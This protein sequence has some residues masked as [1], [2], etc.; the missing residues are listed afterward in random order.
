VATAIVRGTV[1]VTSRAVSVSPTGEILYD[2]K[3]YL[4]GTAP[5]ADGQQARIVVADDQ[6]QRRMQAD[7][8]VYFPPPVP[9][10]R[11]ARRR[12]QLPTGA[13]RSFSAP[14]QPMR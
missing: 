10:N 1:K 3:S 12:R 11:A 2:G 14:T 6:G 4:T 7:F 8:P 5:M 9:E 13:D